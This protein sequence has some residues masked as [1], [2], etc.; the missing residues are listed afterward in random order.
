MTHQRL[1]T[2]AGPAVS[3]RD[4]QQAAVDGIYGWFEG[5]E[6][7]PL[8]VI[9][10]GGGKSVVI[11]AFVRDVLTNFPE[12][13]ILVVTHVRELVQQNHDAMLRMWPQA[14]VGI[15]SAGLKRRDTRAGV[16]FAS[17]QSVYNRADELGAFDLVL[18]DEAHLI[19]SKGFGM[20][21]TLLTDLRTMRPKV[22][23]IGFTATPFR[24][25]TGRL[26]D[27]EE[28][29]FHG[30]AYSCDMLELIERG[31]LCKVVNQGVDHTVDTR[32][33]AVRG[34]DFVEG[35]LERAAMR[36][37]L[38]EQA[39][40]ELCRRAADRRSWI[41]FGC[42]V[43]HARAIEE[44]LK[45]N[46]IAA[47][48][49]FG[50]TSIE[51]RA[52]ILRDYKA[53]LIRCVVN[54]GVLTTGFD[55]PATDAIALLRPTKSAGLYVQ[56]VGRG[57]RVAEGKADCL[58]LDFGDNVLRHGPINDVKVKQPGKGDGEAPMTTC[59]KCQL[60][61][62]AM[63]VYCPRCNHQLRDPNAQKAPDHGAVPDSQSVLLAPKKQLIERWKPTRVIYA[64][65][66]KDPLKP[67]TLRV[68]YLFGYKKTANEFV[69]FEHPAGSF[70][71]RKA[72]MWWRSR[73]G[74][75]PVPHTVDL[76]AVR[77][78]CGAL[79]RVETVIVKTDGEY[80]DVRG[81]ELEPSDP[82]RK[83]IQMENEPV[84]QDKG[85]PDEIPF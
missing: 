10:T 26:D 25:D 79:R 9:P 69:C 55:A 59:P 12:D 40:D 11:A 67:P 48:T 73:G 56:M 82:E 50:S 77:I 29:L 57:M 42:G 8:V 27:G 31:Y 65:H 74:A 76:A 44:R 21:R 85:T 45:T 14:P 61:V 17:V 35:E 39:V 37:D 49:V 52:A 64:E 23:L 7:N 83:A 15:Y 66:Q 3:L 62:P 80:P 51:Q 43:N 36:G 78:E 41:A 47:S 81:V 75:D 71:R 28:R 22:K 70:P 19:P 24:T 18:V 32:G 63:T 60:I 33:V 46:G 54:V 68:T 20:Y 72:E 38:V 2:A 13:R 58:V 34:G 6:G 30:Q 5:N 16:V 1:L 4:Y 84:S 53:G